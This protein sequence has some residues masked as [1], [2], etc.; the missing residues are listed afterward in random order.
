MADAAKKK[1]KRCGP[2]K[3]SRGYGEIYPNIPDSYPGAPGTAWSF[4]LDRKSFRDTKMNLCDDSVTLRMLFGVRTVA[5]FDW[6]EP[7]SRSSG[8]RTGK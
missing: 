6:A 8:Q 5:D 2:W 3:Q 4:L 7:V 1:K